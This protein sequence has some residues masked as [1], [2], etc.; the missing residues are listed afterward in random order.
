MHWNGDSSKIYCE[1]SSSSPIA[2]QSFLH[3]SW[4][5]ARGGH[6]LDTA[7]HTAVRGYGGTE[8]EL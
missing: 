4:L 5:R 6:T 2:I 1:L 3:R 7:G 8:V